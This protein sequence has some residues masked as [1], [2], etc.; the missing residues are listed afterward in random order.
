MTT[1]QAATVKQ[2]YEANVGQYHTKE[3]NKIIKNATTITGTTA[4]G[5]KTAS[6]GA[7]MPSAT[8]KGR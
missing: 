4:F 1:E 6:P 8:W 2:R 7:Q 3:A 5:P